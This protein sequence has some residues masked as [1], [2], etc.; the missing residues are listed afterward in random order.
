MINCSRY[1]FFVFLALLACDTKK[2]PKPEPQEPPLTPLTLSEITGAWRLEAAA[3][4]SPVSITDIYDVNNPLLNSNPSAREG[5]CSKNSMLTLNENGTCSEEFVAN[6]FNFPNSTTQDCP[7][8]TFTGTYILN[9]AA[10][11]ITMTFN[12]PNNDKKYFIKNV[13]NGI[14]IAESE[15][16]QG[17]IPS[18]RSITYRKQ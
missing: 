1:I 10:R 14:M 11:T 3:L 4:L 18:K 7:A 6:T 15:S 16:M 9:S 17:G 5:F 13:E 2:Q 8:A 12:N